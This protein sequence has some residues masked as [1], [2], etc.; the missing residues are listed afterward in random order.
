MLQRIPDVPEGID[1][2]AVVGTLT[3][4]NYGRRD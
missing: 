2:F 3:A 4:D 1:A